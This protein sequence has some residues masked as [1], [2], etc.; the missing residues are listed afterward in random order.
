MENNLG[1][2]ASAAFCDYYMWGT[3]GAFCSSFYTDV[4]CSDVRL[5]EAWV[6]HSTL[7]KKQTNKRQTKAL[8]LTEI[9][10]I[11]SQY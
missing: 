9:A 3:I 11:T 8:K 5:T 1:D 10:K 7:K 4:C 6:Q 2:P